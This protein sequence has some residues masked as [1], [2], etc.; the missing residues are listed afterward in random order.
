MFGTDDGLLRIRAKVLA[1][2][3][4]ETQVV[5]S[6]EEARQALGAERQK[7]QL[8]ILCHTAQEADTDR[9]RSMALQSG[10]PT[11]LVERMIPPQQLVDD[12]KRVLRHGN[13]AI[14]GARTRP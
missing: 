1:T 11:Y 5:C 14:K 9:I 13:A 4:C 3:G 2:I 10:I 8:V 12:V 6:E 7:P